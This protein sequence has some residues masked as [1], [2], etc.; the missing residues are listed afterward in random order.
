M[1]RGHSAHYVTGPPSLYSS[2][3][4]RQAGALPL[5]CPPQMSCG[6]VWTLGP[7]PSPGPEGV[8]GQGVA[9][10]QAPAMLSSSLRQ[11]PTCQA[12]HPGS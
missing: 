5:L 4:P 1:A 2:S 12:G 8:P 6:P 11:T 7:R 3:V 10:P 9:L